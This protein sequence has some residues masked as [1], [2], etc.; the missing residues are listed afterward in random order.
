MSQIKTILMVCTGNSCRSV[1]AG[2]LLEQMLKGKDGFKVITAGV[3]ASTGMKSTQETIQVMSEE[4]IDVSA[5]RSQPI[6]GELV[7]EADLILVMESR[8]KEIIIAQSPQARDKVYLL[9]EF[10]RVKP[11]NEFFLPDISDPIGKSLEFYRK[12]GVIIKENLARVVK[13]LEKQ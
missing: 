5:H 4:G 6:S 11:A 10:G 13:E 12:V 2:G 3:S 8:H 7:A 9:R 1:M